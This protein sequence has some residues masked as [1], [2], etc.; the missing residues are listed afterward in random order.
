MEAMSCDQLTQKNCLPCE[1][2]V[3]PYTREQAIAQL[4]KLE[5]WELTPD[6]QRIRKDWTTKNF[7]AG[8]DF[9]NKVAEVAD[10]DGHHPDL[11]I[12]GYRNVSV[13]LW[14]HAIGGLSEND[15]ILAAKIDQVP[16]ACKG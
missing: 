6:G 14:T 9:F 13:E 1:G 11:H 8:I 7:M 16:V 2:G 4:E 15:F 10:E 5:G 12:A 3:E